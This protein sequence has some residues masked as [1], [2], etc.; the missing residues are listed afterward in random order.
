MRPVDQTTFGVPGGNC[1]S[2]CIASILELPISEVPY[3]MPETIE[4]WEADKKRSLGESPYYAKFVAW[5]GAH[6]FWPLVF[7]ARD[8]IVIPPD[9]WTILG[10][11]SPRGSHSVVGRGGVMVFD[12]HPSRDGIAKAED[13]TVLIPLDPA[14]RVGSAP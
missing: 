2:A 4:E 9:A 7:G 5:C 14:H 13:V 12:P 8:D 6:G 1:F 11:Q 10:G 3:F